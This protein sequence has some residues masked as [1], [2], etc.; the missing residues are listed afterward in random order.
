MHLSV[1]D[2]SVQLTVVFRDQM[3]ATPACVLSLGCEVCCFQIIS[4]SLYYKWKV[5][6]DVGLDWNKTECKEYTSYIN[7]KIGNIDEH[8]LNWPV[9]HNDSKIDDCNCI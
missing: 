1:K 2:I 7:H 3:A 4:Y 6:C 8:D 9:C 5:V